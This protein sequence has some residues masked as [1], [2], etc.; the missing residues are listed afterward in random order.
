[1]LTDELQQDHESQGH[2]QECIQTVH[3]VCHVAA[4]LSVEEHFRS[5]LS[6]SYLICNKVVLRPESNLAR[7][8]QGDQISTP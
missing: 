2:E 3:G 7:L 4:L 6:E 5:A 1:M 8:Q